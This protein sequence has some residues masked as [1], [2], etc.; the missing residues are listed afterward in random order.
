[1]KNI[2]TSDHTITGI[3][4]GGITPSTFRGNTMY[5]HYAGLYLINVAVIDTQ[6]HAGNRWLGTYSSSYGAVNMNDSTF[7]NLA[8]SLFIIDPN[9]GS[10][11]SPAIPTDTLDPPFLVND[12]GWVSFQLLGNTFSCTG[13]FSCNA[14]LVGGGSEDLKIL[15]ARDSTLTAEYIPQSKSI[16]KQYLF[17]VLKQDSII[18]ANNAELQTFLLMNEQSNIGYLYETK[19]ALKQTGELSLNDKSVIEEI[20]SLFNTYAGNLYAMSTGDTGR[21]MLITTLS[22]LSEQ[23]NSIIHQPTLIANNL[24][25]AQNNNTLVTGGDDP[26]Q[27]QKLINALVMA[28]LKGGKDSISLNEDLLLAI[29]QQFPYKGGRAVYEARAMLKLFNDTIHYNDTQECLMQGIYRFSNSTAEEA[30]MATIDI[31]P[32]PARE[33]AIIKLNGLTEGICHV[34][35]HNMLNE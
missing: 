33:K 18:S 27:N 30:K 13:Q 17:D 28:Y 3:Y 22:D 7:F 19:E 21:M 26:V 16:A 15:I 8:L 24:T 6:T 2:N 20:D 4:F 1:M 5:D 25:V 10:D 12:Q 31:I 29:A 23:Q 9:L 35:I 11:Y 14:F 32:N 34:E